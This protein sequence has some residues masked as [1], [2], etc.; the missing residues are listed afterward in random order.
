MIAN[1]LQPTTTATYEFVWASEIFFAG[2][3]QFWS[4][5]FISTVLSGIPGH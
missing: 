3:I 4:V 5:L 2:D 1:E